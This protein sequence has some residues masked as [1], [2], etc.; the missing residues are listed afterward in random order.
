MTERR[1]ASN[2]R[3]TRFLRF[4]CRY[5]QDQLYVLCLLQLSVFQ[6]L[7]HLQSGLLQI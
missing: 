2:N 6:G 4:F 1:K 5:N 7:E 3:L